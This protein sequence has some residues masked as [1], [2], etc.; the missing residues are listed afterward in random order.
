MSDLEPSPPDRQLTT[1]A[2]TLRLTGALLALVAG[3][4]A[5]VIAIQLVRS[6]LS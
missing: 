2:V 5:L 6:A 4:A 3:T 1:R